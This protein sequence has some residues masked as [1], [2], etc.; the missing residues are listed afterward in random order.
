MSK[1]SKT[2]GSKTFGEKTRLTLSVGFIV[3]ALGGFTTVIVS[4]VDAKNKL[5]QVEKKADK[6][7][8]KNID[9]DEVIKNIENLLIRIDESLKHIGEDVK[10]LKRR[11]K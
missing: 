6:N 11:R 10:D 1:E 9:Q 4:G 7:E 3:L 8:E 5:E 2:N